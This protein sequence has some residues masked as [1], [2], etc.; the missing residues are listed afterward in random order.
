MDLQQYEA[1]K[2]LKLSEAAYSEYPEPFKNWISEWHSNGT[3]KKAKFTI[4]ISKLYV[5][6]V[7]G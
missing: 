3:F 4:K 7:K 1:I 2:E 6:L 5:E